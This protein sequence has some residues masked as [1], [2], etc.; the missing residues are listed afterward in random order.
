MHL[1]LAPSRIKSQHEMVMVDFFRVKRTF[2]A[3]PHSRPLQPGANQ[4]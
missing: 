3:R 4:P 2:G 1:S